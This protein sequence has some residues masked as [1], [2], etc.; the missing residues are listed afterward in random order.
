MTRGRQRKSF[1]HRKDNQA[2]FTAVVN[3]LRSLLNPDSYY[4]PEAQYSPR[5]LYTSTLPYTNTSSPVIVI[6]FASANLRMLAPLHR[7]LRAQ[8]YKV[9]MEIEN[10][11]ERKSAS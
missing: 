3:D 9:A 8:T 2:K 6:D 4:K 11:S 5:V 10:N 7:Q 1:G